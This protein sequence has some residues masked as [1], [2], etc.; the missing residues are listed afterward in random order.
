MLF[1]VRILNLIKSDYIHELKMQERYVKNIV[2]YKFL[3]KNNT[4]LCLNYNM[5]KMFL[6]KQN[7]V[8]LKYMEREELNFIYNNVKAAQ[9]EFFKD[10]TC[11]QTKQIILK[12]TRDYFS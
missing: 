6:Q 3:N 10:Q 12:Y 7:M 11:L 1:G 9:Q 8:L 4:M 2:R 5:I